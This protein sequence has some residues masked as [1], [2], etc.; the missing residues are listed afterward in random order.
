LK[1][2][3][4]ENHKKR[5]CLSL[6]YGFF[7]R[8]DKYNFNIENIK[9]SDRT[10]SNDKKT[11]SIKVYSPKMDLIKNG[12][13]PMGNEENSKKNSFLFT[14]IKGVNKKRIIEV[15]LIKLKH[16]N[17]L[18]KIVPVDKKWSFISKAWINGRF[19]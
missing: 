3:I 2:R 18:F 6:L 12:H 16:V 14:R 15:P 1:N 11:F 8:E 5:N 10:K 13:N 4:I 17:T 9:K 19:L 7:N